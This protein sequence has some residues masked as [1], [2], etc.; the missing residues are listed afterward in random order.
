M[1]VDFKQLCSLS[2]I[3]TL[4]SSQW[5]SVNCHK[6]IGFDDIFTNSVIKISIPQN[7]VVKIFYGHF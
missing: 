6:K 4:H 1:M 5:Y 7:F 2:G 3:R